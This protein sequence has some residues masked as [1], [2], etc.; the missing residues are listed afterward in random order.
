MN[1]KFF[2]FDLGRVL[3]DFTHDRGFQQ[4]AEVSGVP[5]QQVREL[6]VTERLGDRYE[7]GEVSTA[8]FHAAF[9]ESTHSNVT[10]EELSLAWAD[11]FELIPQTVRLA[12]SLWMAGYPLG[13]LSNTCEAH[14]LHAV[15]RYPVLGELFSKVVTSYD[16]K[17]MKPDREIYDQAEKLAGVDA[18]H[19]FF[20][21][22]RLENVEA[23]T[24]LGWTARQF[25][26]P[27]QLANEL[28]ELGVVFNR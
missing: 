4:I 9:C 11:I 6:M 21:D 24:A 28:D 1:I 8:D 23:A 20:V 25:A 15:Q 16:A 7:L 10:V 12:A 5:Q 22:D 13:I 27:L 26:S 14:W 2:Y 3:L 19:L 18:S 17:S